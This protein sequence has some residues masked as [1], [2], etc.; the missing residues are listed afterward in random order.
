MKELEGK[1]KDDFIKKAM[2]MQGYSDK[3]ANAMINQSMRTIGSSYDFINRVPDRVNLFL[4][5]KDNQ[6]KDKR[7]FPVGDDWGQVDRLLYAKMFTKDSMQKALAAIEPQLPEGMSIQVRDA[8]GKVYYTYPNNIASSKRKA[9][10]SGSLTGVGTG[11]STVGNISYPYYNEFSVLRDKANARGVGLYSVEKL[12]DKMIAVCD[13]QNMIKNLK[14]FAYNHRNDGNRSSDSWLN[15]MREEITD[16]DYSLS[17]EPNENDYRNLT[18][19]LNKYCKN[20]NV[21]EYYNFRYYP[22]EKYGGFYI[23][24]EEAN[25][26]MRTPDPMTDYIKDELGKMGWYAENVYSPYDFTIGICSCTFKA[27][28]GTNVIE[29]KKK[30]RK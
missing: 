19:K 26:N 13:D 2:K 29:S 14:D 15:L 8:K 30:V 3:E 1:S 7:Y 18:D 23:V 6:A 10:K 12:V 22:D 5:S 4:Y 16:K 28:A 25:C 27:I 24:D 17:R 21:S 20:H 9:I 11:L